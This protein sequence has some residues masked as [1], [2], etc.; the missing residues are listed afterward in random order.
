MLK[1]VLDKTI[2]KWGISKT[3]CFVMFTLAGASC[4]GSIAIMAIPNDPE[5][6]NI[7]EKEND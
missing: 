1:Y 7:E 3:I 2:R 5:A 4:A 6:D